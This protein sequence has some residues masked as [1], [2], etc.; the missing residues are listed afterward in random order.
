MAHMKKI[1]YLG[2]DGNALKTFL[3][4]LEE[5]SVS[6]AALKLNLSQSAISHTLDK[7]RIAFDDPLFVR[8][9]RGIAPTKKGKSL[10]QPIKKILNELKSLTYRDEFDPIEKEMEFTI[11]ANDF[12]VMFI[13]PKLLKQ[14]RKEGVNIKFNF[15]PSGVPS[16]N[17][18]R[19]RTSRCQLL[20]TPAPP[21]GSEFVIKPLLETKMVCFY[22]SDY[23]TPPKTKEEFINSE[24]VEVKFGE[25][26]S[27]MMV[28]SSLDR[29]TLNPPCIT[30]PNFGSVSSFIKGSS[31]ITTQLSIMKYGSMSGLSHASLPFDS[32]PVTLYLVWHQHD[33]DDPAHSWLRQRIINTFDSLFST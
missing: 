21:T 10:E 23:R 17:P 27:S 22:D 8:D 32:D 3:A 14:L 1:D 18:A 15:T 26:E 4:V 12:P 30:V 25:K 16:A 29:S 24:Y 31:L 11:A 2:L 13:F 7:L 20:I 28:L 33:N 6:K 5:N 19:A 9:G